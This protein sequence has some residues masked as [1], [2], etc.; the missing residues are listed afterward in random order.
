MEENQEKQGPG[1][2]LRC[3]SWS[4]VL[5]YGGMRQCTRLGID[6]GPAFGC[7]LFEAVGQPVPEAAPLPPLTVGLLA[8]VLRELVHELTS[9]E[10]LPEA[11]RR[12]V[13]QLDPSAVDYGVEDCNDA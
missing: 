12:I 7:V 13:A 10:P 3:R 11:L 4:G 5:P 6:V 8:V 1:F 2:C 9:T